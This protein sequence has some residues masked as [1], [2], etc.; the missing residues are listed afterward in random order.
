MRSS[1][2]KNIN[3]EDETITTLLGTD[4]NRH[5]TSVDS[6]LDWLSKFLLFNS[7]RTHSIYHIKTADEL[8]RFAS[9]RTWGLVLVDHIFTKERY[10]SIIDLANKAS[11]VLA[12]DAESS[13]DVYKY[14]ENKVTAHFK[15]ACKMSMFNETQYKSTL[16]LS[17]FIDIRF[18][19]HVFGR[20]KYSAK[21]VA[22][23]YK[24]F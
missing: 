5:V 3:H 7:T 12:H 21:V 4:M 24:D 2:N 20:I 23:N 10:K 6:D 22:C 19:E 1:N 15:Y 13:H 16:M 17:N 18:L 9:D 14:A 11:L 8:R